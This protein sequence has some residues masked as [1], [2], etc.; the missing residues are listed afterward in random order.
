M[1]SFEVLGI[2]DTFLGLPWLA[3]FSK[4]ENK[5]YFNGF[6]LKTVGVLFSKNNSNRARTLYGS[7][8]FAYLRLVHSNILA[9]PLAGK[10]C[11]YH[12]P[13][14]FVQLPE[15]ERIENVRI[16]GGGNSSRHAHHDVIFCNKGCDW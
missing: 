1:N 2:K 6:K 7:E 14:A 4:I 13:D 8:S 3:S 15:Y 12:L 10:T 5:I 16:S 9:M 11:V